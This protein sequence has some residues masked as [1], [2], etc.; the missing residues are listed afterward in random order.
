MD[1]FLIRT[2]SRQRSHHD[3]M[4]EIESPDAEGLEKS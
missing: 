1:V 4:L 2:E 3:A